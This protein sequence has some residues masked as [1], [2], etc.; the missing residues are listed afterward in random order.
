MPDNLRRE[1]GSAPFRPGPQEREAILQAIAGRRSIRGF[2]PDTVEIT[3]IETILRVASRAPS[4]TNIQPWR[5]HVLTGAARRKLTNAILAY[6]KAHPDQ[7][8]GEYRYYPDRWRDPYLARRRKIGWDLYGLLGVGKSNREGM[9]AQHDRN[10]DFFGAP[11]GL[12]FSMDRDLGQGAFIDMG[13]FMQNVM[14]AARA[15]GLDTCPQAAFTGYHAIIRE[16]LGLDDAAMVI[17]G[18][19]LGLTDPAAPANQ[20]VTEREP[21]ESFA[22]FLS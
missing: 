19:A 6:R 4:G 18:M 5:V 10:F 15:F 1:D 16:H 13:M 11:A 14:I 17:S 2:L 12:I 22:S 8:D 21:V 7:P 20:L 9:R 3:T